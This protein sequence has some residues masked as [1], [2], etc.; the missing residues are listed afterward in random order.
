M[1]P[2]V[3]ITPNALSPA[4]ILLTRLAIALALI[5]LVFSLLWW[6]RDG[7]RDQQDGEV[8]FTDV[9]YFTMITVTTVGYGD[10]VPVST[11]AR[12]VDALVVTPIRFGI[13]FL[14][15]GTAYQ[16]ILRRYMEGYRM[17]KLQQTL[18][19]H[20][21]IC[22]FGHTGV[23]ATKEL[24]ARDITAE[25]ILVIDKNE[26]RVRLAG[27]LGVSAF[28]A[29]ATQEAVLREA[30]IDK[31]K[32]LIIATD[33]DDSTALI[34]LTARHLHPTVRIVVSAKEQENVKLFKQGGA[35]AI[36]SPATFGGCILAAA[37]DQ[38][39][40]VQYLDDLLSA[41]G[42]IALVERP[43]RDNEIGKA[44]A[45]LKPDLLLRLYRGNRMVPLTDIESAGS[46]QKGDIMV[47]LTTGQKRTTR[48]Q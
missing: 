46:L 34:L 8:S 25:K 7:L 36:I 45:E 20:L 44:P 13:W 5:C 9:V 37:V 39:H 4:G 23:S 29:D 17:A 19:E 21:I 16:L 32:A 28:Q 33:R 24:L 40:M 2:R 12:L 35:D 47:L 15:L 22:G 30:V 10:I 26:E 48:D 38:G 31:A 6:D 41:S 27:S 14:F 43:V 42:N 18:K 1:G 11:R 3:L